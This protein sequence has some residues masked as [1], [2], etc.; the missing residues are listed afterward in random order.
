MTKTNKPRDS[1]H[2]RTHKEFSQRT[3]IGYDLKKRQIIS[4][5]EGLIQKLRLAVHRLLGR[6]PPDALYLQPEVV[7]AML[8][9]AKKSEENVGLVFTR[10]MFLTLA[11]VLNRKERKVFVRALTRFFENVESLGVELV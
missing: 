8:D 1:A 4:W 3:F 6:C 9:Y 2:E 7:E 5:E 11:V 10:D